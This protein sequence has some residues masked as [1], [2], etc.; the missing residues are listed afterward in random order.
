MNF[1]LTLLNGLLNTIASAHPEYA[2][3]IKTV[4][5]HED[6]ADEIVDVIRNAVSEGSSAIAAARQAAP[7]LEAAVRKLV[8][9]LPGH[10]VTAAAAADQ[11]ETGVEN[12]LRNL[13]GLPHMTPDQERDWMDKTTARL[14][15]SQAGGG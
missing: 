7:N 14:N 3:V 2:S 5:A 15:D 8:S 12:V 9:S 13:G 4:I 11:I 10:A 6:K 1:K